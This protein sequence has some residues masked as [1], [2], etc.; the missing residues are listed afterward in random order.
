[1]RI[2]LFARLPGWYPVRCDRLAARLMQEGHEVAGIVVERAPT[3]ATL[4][5]WLAKLGPGLCLKKGL[6]LAARLLGRPLGRLWKRPSARRRRPPVL[7]VPSHNSSMTVDL[8][9]ALSPD[10]I[11]LRG[12]G[13]IQWPILEIPTLGTMGLHDAA[14]PAFRGRDVT[15]WAALLGGPMAVSLHFVTEGLDTG[16][17][18]A[19]RRVPVEAGD[20][21]GRLREKSAA[22]A[23]D[24]VVEALDKLTAGTAVPRSQQAGD[25]RQYFAMHPRLK[26]LASEKLRRAS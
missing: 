2:V 26:S 7:L 12:C 21:L 5:D 1:M 14:L 25:G 10:V 3:L 20:T 15:E 4:R 11:V 24:L 16:A 9:R 17:V 19:S 18:L 13:I 23:A 22:L 8:V 6:A